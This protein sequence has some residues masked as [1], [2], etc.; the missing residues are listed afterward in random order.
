M[1][2]YIIISAIIAYLIGSIPS[3]VWIGKALYGV[4][5]RKEGSGNAGATNTIRILGWKAG[6]PVL[7]IDVLK[8]WFAVYLANLFPFDFLSKDSLEIMKM[9]LSAAAV[10]GHVFPVYTGFR[11]GKGVATLVGVGIALYPVAVWVVVG[12]FIVVLLISRIVSVSSIIA[13][14]SFPFIVYFLFPAESKSLI[15]LAIAVAIF[16]PLTHI[17]NIKRLIIGTEKPF[18]IKTKK[19]S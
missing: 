10:L 1:I 18:K 14:L 9:G 3:S 16:V 6:I 2:V 19:N 15:I 11:G 8:G 5:V 4:D 12:V 13:A 17:K 7:I